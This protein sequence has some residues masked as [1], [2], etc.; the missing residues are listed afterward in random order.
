MH[1][2]RPF[3]VVGFNVDNLAEAMTAV[4]QGRKATPGMQTGE[5]AVRGVLRRAAGAGVNAVRTWAHTT[6]PDQPLQVSA[7]VYSEDAM[8]AL[9]VVIAEAQA[10]GLRVVLSLADNWKYEGGVDEFV[11]WAPSVPARDAK[12]PV[13]TGG[14]GDV[15]DVDWSDERREYEA[16]RKALFFT[17]TGVKKLYRAHARAVSRR[18]GEKGGVLRAL[19]SPPLGPPCVRSSVLPG[20]GMHCVATTAAPHSPSSPLVCAPDPGAR[21]LRDGP[22]VQERP[23]DHGTGPAERAALRG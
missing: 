21:Q 5:A 8:H 11:D 9:D 22:D 13:A 17:D 19:G 16:R 23:H 12:Y 14:D 4:T 7:G 6:N 15:S 10:A 18:G 3:Y 1:K 20:Q 2:C